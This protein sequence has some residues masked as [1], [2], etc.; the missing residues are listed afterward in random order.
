MALIMFPGPAIYVLDKQ[1][2]G[3]IRYV[4]SVQRAAEEVLKWPNS[5]KRDK[6]ALLLADV[7][8]GKA[9]PEAAKKAFIEA[10]REIQ[11]LSRGL[12]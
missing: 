11:V 4:N 7:L 3:V 12:A 9:K 8:A 2:L 1:K 5:R 6:A 10:A